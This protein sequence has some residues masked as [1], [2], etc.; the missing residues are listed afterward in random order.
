MLPSAEAHR[1]VLCGAVDRRGC[2]KLNRIIAAEQAN[3]RAARR[4]RGLPWAPR[5]GRRERDPA[6]WRQRERADGVR[7]TRSHYPEMMPTKGFR[8]EPHIWRIDSMAA[9]SFDFPLV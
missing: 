6:R 7:E 4:Q 3:H 8:E 1:S 2:P 5:R 9:T